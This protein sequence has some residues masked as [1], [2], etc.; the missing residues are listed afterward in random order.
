MN[1]AFSLHLSCELA[2]TFTFIS[3]EYP[4]ST[5]WTRDSKE[6]SS[7]VLSLGGPVSRT[8][9]PIHI[10][11]ASAPMVKH[12]AGAGLKASRPRVMSKSGHSNVYPRRLRLPMPAR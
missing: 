11:M 10:S 3:Q 9:D 12:T 6:T 1:L 8:M 7:F 5:F 4:V 2:C